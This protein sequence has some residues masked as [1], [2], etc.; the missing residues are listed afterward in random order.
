MYRIVF[1][2]EK[3]PKYLLPLITIPTKGQFKSFLTLRTISKKRDK[4]VKKVLTIYQNLL[5]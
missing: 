3:I 2:T 1:E 5:S 4:K